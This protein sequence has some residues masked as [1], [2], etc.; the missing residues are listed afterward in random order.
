MEAWSVRKA[1]DGDGALR[2]ANARTEGIKPSNRTLGPPQR[3]AIIISPLLSLL[4]V[5][6]L[7]T[8]YLTLHPLPVPEPEL[9][10][11]RSNPSSL[12]TWKLPRPTVT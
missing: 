5:I 4:P 12:T 10:E 7:D 11:P 6:D 2:M 8:P 1:T 9:P 3:F